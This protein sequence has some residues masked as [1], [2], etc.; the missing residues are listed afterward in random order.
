[1]CIFIFY[2]KG[3]HKVILIKLGR[4]V[5]EIKVIKIVW[6]VIVN[7]LIGVFGSV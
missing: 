2:E 1:M 3:D 5:K 4:Y 6:N 7:S